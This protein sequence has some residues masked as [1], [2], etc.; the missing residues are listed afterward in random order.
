[1]MEFKIKPFP[2]TQV[3]ET[4]RIRLVSNTD[5]EVQV[6][7]EL[8]R[9]DGRVMETGVKNFPLQSVGIIA[10]NPIPLPQLNA[11]LAAWNLEAV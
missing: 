5:A 4:L 7:Y 8:V 3:A 9:A 10:Q 11:L 2:I 1:M 6:Y